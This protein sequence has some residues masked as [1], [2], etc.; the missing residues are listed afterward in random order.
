MLLRRSSSAVWLAA[1]VDEAEAA[2]L[3]LHQ[4]RPDLALPQRL[5]VAALLLELG[6]ER[7]DLLGRCRARVNE[8]P[9][10]LLLGGDLGRQGGD[11][12]G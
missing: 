12:V 1:Q 2:L 10:L 9:E 3:G 4:G 6:G 8:L 11:P 7:S 5:L